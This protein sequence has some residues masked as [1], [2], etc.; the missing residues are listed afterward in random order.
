MNTVNMNEYKRMQIVLPNFRP[1]LLYS[2]AY[3]VWFCLGQHCI[4]QGET[5]K[6]AQ[7]HWQ[8]IIDN[9]HAGRRHERI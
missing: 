3:E 7:D 2:L 9:L 6:Q 1:H 8:Q 4:G 5:Q